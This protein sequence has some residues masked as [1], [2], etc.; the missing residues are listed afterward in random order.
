MA[1]RYT[2]IGIDV[3]DCILFSDTLCW[4][5]EQVLGS[6]IF[7]ED[8]HNI[9]LQMFHKIYD[10]LI[11]LI[12]LDKMKLMST[13]KISTQCKY[14]KTFPIP[15]ISPIS[16]YEESFK[17]ESSLSSLKSSVY[18]SKQKSQTPLPPIKTQI[19]SYSPPPSV[20]NCDDRIRK[21]HK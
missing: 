17:E 7:T 1:K 18:M 3:I 15:S 10:V 2:D 11:P 8:T 14:H 12:I 21:T 16:S 9:F 19:H 5:F 20:F 6:Y 4:T 13:I